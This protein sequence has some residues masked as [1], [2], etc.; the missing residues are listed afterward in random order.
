MEFNEDVPQLETDGRNWSAWH[1]SVTTVI[2]K[3]GLYSYVDGTVS[4]PDRQLEA[5]AKFFLTIGLPDIIFGSMLHLVTTHDCYKYLKNQFDKSLVQPLQ[6]RLQE[7]QVPGDAEPQVAARNPNS[8][9]GPCR[10]CGKRGHKAHECGK[11]RIELESVTVEEK[12]TG[13]RR[14]PRHHTEGS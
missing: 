4:E 7:V 9:N 10:K 13:S 12:L 14:K 1:K 3:A 8:F 6:R 11:V 2:N 5:M